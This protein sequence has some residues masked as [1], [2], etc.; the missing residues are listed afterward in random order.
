[1]PKTT[2]DSQPVR[3]VVRGSRARLEA[4]RDREM[5]EWI[6]RFRFVTAELL[7][8]RFALSPQRVN[9]RLRRLEAAGL[10]ARERAAATQARAA[11]VTGVG[12]RRLG[13]RVRRAPRTNAQREHELAIVAL[14]AHLERSHGARD[15]RVLTEREQRAAEADS[16][17]QFSVELRPPARGEL[18]R[19]PD[20]VIETPTARIAIELELSMK[21]PERLKRIVAGYAATTTYTDVRFLAATP[22]IAVRYAALIA[23]ETAHRPLATMLDLSQTRLIVEPWPGADAETQRRI[24]G[25]LA[26]TRAV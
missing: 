8:E 5:L 15:H 19:W 14:V 9:A 6:A 20:A 17:A 24:T 3:M 22:G 7:G 26:A 12:A 10:V 16:T 1:M 25:A 4:E 23:R 13:V 11:F 2:T 21:A 18:R